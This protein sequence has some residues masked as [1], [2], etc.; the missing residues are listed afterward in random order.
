MKTKSN[1]TPEAAHLACVCGCGGLP[2]GAKSHFIPG[3]DA[4]YHA[5]QKKAASEVSP[6]A[7]T[8]VNE[9]PRPRRAKRAAAGHDGTSRAAGSDA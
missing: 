1:E 4:R 9:P 8:N 5:A 3:H 7:P 2:K 6:A